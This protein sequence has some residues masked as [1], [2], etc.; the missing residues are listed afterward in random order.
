MEKG[1]EGLDKLNTALD[2]FI[3][4]VD[5]EAKVIFK[6]VAMDLITA[7]T[8][9]TP[10]DTGTARGN[11]FIGIN[12]TPKNKQA[13][14]YKEKKISESR[15]K[16]IDHFVKTRALIKI[17]DVEIGDSIHVANNIEY[18]GYLDEGTEKMAPFSMT[19]KAMEAIKHGV[20]K[21]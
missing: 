8:Y 12:K 6:K 4:D 2:D 10:V 13:K 21:K 9:Y 1:I 11:W 18:V 16:A 7:L 5:I 3:K 17:K 20:T 15:V 14:T 19:T